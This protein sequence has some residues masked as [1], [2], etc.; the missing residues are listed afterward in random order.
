MV[1]SETGDGQGPDN[2]SQMPH[3]A[4][5]SSYCRPW[6]LCK[7]FEA[8]RWAELEDLGLQGTMSSERVGWARLRKDHDT[9]LKWVDFMLQGITE[10]SDLC[11]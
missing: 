8:G 3:E 2:M 1:A 5:W 4:V 6:R 7:S 11:V 10:D 9:R